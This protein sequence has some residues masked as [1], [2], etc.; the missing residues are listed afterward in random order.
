MLQLVAAQWGFS[1]SRSWRKAVRKLRTR[2]HRLPAATK[3]Q[4]PVNNAQPKIIAKTILGDPDHYC[5][6]YNHPKKPILISLA[7]SLIVLAT[8]SNEVWSNRS[9]R[10]RLL[11]FH[12][13]GCISRL[14]VHHT[15]ERAGSRTSEKFDQ[16]TAE[17]VSP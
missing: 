11:V 17:D 9:R 4:E 6:S 15:R 8:S 14:R 1:G 5:I 16:T 2:A 7:P 13:S 12:P 3:S 10:G